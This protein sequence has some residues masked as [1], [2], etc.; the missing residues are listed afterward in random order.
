M[1]FPTLALVCL[2]YIMIINTFPCFS[3]FSFYT[4]ASVWVHIIVYI[5]V[6]F[7]IT[8]TLMT[9]ICVP[10][11]G[12]SSVFTTASG[13]AA[14]FEL[15]VSFN[16]TNSSDIQGSYLLCM[17][18]MQ[19]QKS[20]SKKINKMDSHWKWWRAWRVCNETGKGGPI[21]RITPSLS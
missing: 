11:A 10:T 9:F 8:L 17:T 20:S 3:L 16:S 14:S 18:A 13:S 2:T 6:A 12:I 4:F 15:R 19:E 1:L 5:W 21:Q 7:L